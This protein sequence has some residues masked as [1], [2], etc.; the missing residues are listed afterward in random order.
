LSAE[1]RERILQVAGV[2]G[3]AGPD[4]A[5]RALTPRSLALALLSGHEQDDLVPATDI[6]PC[7]CCCS[8]PPR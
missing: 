3:Y 4:A 7:C 2:L 1:L 8:A 6:A 5:G